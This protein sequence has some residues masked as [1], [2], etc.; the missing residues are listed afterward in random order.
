M[1]QLKRIIFV[2]KILINFQKI[3]KTKILHNYFRKIASVSSYNLDTKNTGLNS[4]IQL[5]FK[6]LKTK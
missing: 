6:N 1:G 5:F 4:G 2:E 3:T